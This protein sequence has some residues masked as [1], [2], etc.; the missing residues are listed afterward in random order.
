MGQI[1]NIKL[2]IV[3]DI[4]IYIHIAKAIFISTYYNSKVERSFKKRAEMQFQAKMIYAA[5]LLF[6]ILLFVTQD[7]DAVSGS[8]N[9]GAGIAIGDEETL[10][11]ALQRTAEELKKW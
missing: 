6:I 3:T 8:A 4:K 7:V 5:M 10:S 2:H 11:D 1:K 9:A